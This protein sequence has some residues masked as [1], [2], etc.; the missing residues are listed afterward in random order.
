MFVSE[1]LANPQIISP[2]HRRLR[3]ILYQL[4]KVACSLDSLTDL[5]T[6]VI[7]DCLG[8]EIPATVLELLPAC[9][10]LEV[11]KIMIGT[12]T[13]NIDEHMHSSIERNLWIRLTSIVKNVES[14]GSEIHVVFKR[15]YSPRTISSAQAR[16][17]NLLNTEISLEQLAGICDIEYQELIRILRSL[18]KSR[19]VNMY[20]R[21]DSNFLTEFKYQFP[22]GNYTAIPDDARNVSSSQ[23]LA[24]LLF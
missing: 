2:N 13:I 21:N 11:A 7:D 19:I 17:L 23:R 5:Q 22:K 14:D 1:I 9:V 8:Y 12:C 18:E 24:K 20:L 16:I 4:L 3:S 10:R 15:S 6:I